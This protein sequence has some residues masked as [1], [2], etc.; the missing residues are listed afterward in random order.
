MSCTPAPSF[1]SFLSFFLYFCSLG[2]EP[3]PSHKPAKCPNAELHPV[4]LLS[5]FL[6][7]PHSLRVVGRPCVSLL[8]LS[9]GSLRP[10]I[11]AYLFAP[12]SL[13][14]TTV[15][16]TRKGFANTTALSCRAP[17]TSL[18]SFTPQRYAEVTIGV[19][20][21]RWEYCTLP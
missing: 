16:D 15:P 5:Y 20:L 8:I 3:R 2:M 1:P 4:L 17:R 11:K 18:V 7:Q 10:R 21:Y 13:C 19:P 12:E 6:L 14:L 9:W